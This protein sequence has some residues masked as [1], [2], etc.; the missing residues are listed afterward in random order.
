MM[1]FIT[2]KINYDKPPIIVTILK[3][4]FIHLLLTVVSS[5]LL[6]KTINVTHIPWHSFIPFGLIL[7]T[8]SFVS[9]AAAPWVDGYQR[10][11]GRYIEP[12]YLFHSKGKFYDRD[13][14]LMPSTQRPASDGAPRDVDVVPPEKN[15][16][17]VPENAKLNYLG[18][19]WECIRG[20]RRQAFS[21][22]KVEMPENA[23]LN[24]SGDDWQC[25]RGFRQSQGN[26]VAVPV[27][28]NATL[29]YYGNSWSCNRGFQQR[30][31]QC[32]NVQVPENARLNQTGTGWK[33]NFGFI[34]QNQACARVEIPDNAKINYYGNGWNC[35]PGYLKQE[36][37]CVAIQ[38]PENGRLNY[39]GSG[40]QCKRGYFKNG[41]LCLKNSS[42]HP[43]P[44][45]SLAY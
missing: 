39:F 45:P 15:T 10:S 44:P 23:K 1:Y 12:H 11:D 30:D 31:G 21:C 34:Q 6:A 43:E 22:S 36:T 19:D 7:L 26:C 24:Y 33:C 32:I 28:E 2:I 25:E 42:K 18:T 9:Q 5:M 3:R 37:A 20:Y 8:I 29:S 35:R 40:W 16:I 27:P 13:A 14:L 17:E 38:V 41:D 4:V